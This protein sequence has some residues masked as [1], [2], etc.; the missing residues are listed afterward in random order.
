MLDLDDGI[1][2]GVLNRLG[3]WVTPWRLGYEASGHRL[4]MRQTRKA[5]DVGDSL[6]EQGYA[7]K[8]HKGRYRSTGRIPKE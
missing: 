4:E 1:A 8:G 2:L 5:K 7:K 3:G 6:V